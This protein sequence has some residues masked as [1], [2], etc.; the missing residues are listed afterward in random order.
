MGFHLFDVQKNPDSDPVPKTDLLF[1]V[2]S[3]SSVSG[4]RLDL[5]C[6][7]DSRLVRDSFLHLSTFRLS[8]QSRHTTWGGVV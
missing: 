3:S 6:T 2:P 7:K 8:L 4:V 5:G 1:P